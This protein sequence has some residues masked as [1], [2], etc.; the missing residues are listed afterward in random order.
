[1]PCFE[2]VRLRILVAVLLVTAHALG[3][4]RFAFCSRI[5]D[6]SLGTHVKS[7]TPFAGGHGRVRAMVNLA[8]EKARRATNGHHARQGASR[9]LFQVRSSVVT[10]TL[11]GVALAIMLTGEA[12]AG[13]LEEA[14]AAYQQGDY[15]TALQLWR[16]RAELGVALAQNNLGL[17]Y[18]NGQ[19]VP[20]DYGEAAKWY[21]L[22]AEQGNVTAQSN[23]A[24][25]YFSG[26]GVPQDYVQ[27][28]VWVS[29]SASRLPPSAR[30]EK[31]QAARHRDIVAS[32]MTPSQI[33]DAQKQVEEWKPKR[34]GR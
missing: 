29:L 27:A 30:D 6:L 32:K 13:P 11:T 28:Y 16:P 22:A 2:A 20:R 31:A 3:V 26:V 5:D 14:W 8:Q 9:A 1:M 25:M 12:V 33:A 10:R 19:G 21:R 15:A 4:R 7:R 23:L 17:M 18:Y 24:S 34:A